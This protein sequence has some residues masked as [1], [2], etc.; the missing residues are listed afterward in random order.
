MPEHQI[1]VANRHDSIIMMHL[2]KQDAIADPENLAGSRK[3]H[4]AIPSGP[5]DPGHCAWSYSSWA[6]DKAAPVLRRLLSSGSTPRASV[7]RMRSTRLYST[8]GIDRVMYGSDDIPVR[9]DAW[10]YVSFGFAW[11]YL[12][13]RTR[14]STSPLRRPAH[15]PLRYEQLRAMQPDLHL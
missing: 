9:V 7:S 2:S 15:V 13:P 1:E 6:I 10:K 4:R 8:V 11:A 5:M 14:P 3:S 12:S